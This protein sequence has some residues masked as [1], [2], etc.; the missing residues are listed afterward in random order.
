MV[1]K[2]PAL[3][4]PGTK[5][6]VGSGNGEPKPNSTLPEEA[7]R[8]HIRPMEDS[9]GHAVAGPHGYVFWDP[10]GAL[11]GGGKKITGRLPTDRRSFYGSGGQASARD[12]AAAPSRARRWSSGTAAGSSHLTQAQAASDTIGASSAAEVPRR[13]FYPARRLPPPEHAVEPSPRSPRTVGASSADGQCKTRRWTAASRATQD[14]PTDDC[15]ALNDS[16]EDDLAEEEDAQRCTARPRRQARS[17]R[18]RLSLPAKVLVQ[19]QRSKS[20]R[21]RSRARQR[22]GRTAQAE[23]I[24]QEVGQ[25]VDR[26]DDEPVPSFV[27]AAAIEDG[28]LHSESLPL[29]PC[30]ISWDWP[31]SRHE[32]KARV[33][34]IDRHVL[35]IER[36]A[37][38]DELKAWKRRSS[39]SVAQTCT[40]T[41]CSTAS[42][43][44]D[45]SP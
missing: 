40:S 28:V 10:E 6:V 43:E 42:S 17:R 23:E 14:V 35:T 22:A 24:D 41:R 1:R 21:A 36:M 2:P 34:M 33:L 11:S 15:M 7:P 31:L 38:I 8:S 9:E 25:G 44:V 4:P 20:L 26:E 13:S 45:S 18:R 27:A 29:P 16:V 3:S 5:L 30:S 12:T 37:L 32:K 39:A 19:L